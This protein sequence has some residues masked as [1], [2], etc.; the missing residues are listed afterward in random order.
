MNRFL[1]N[2]GR[3]VKSHKNIV[4]IILAALFLELISAAQYYYAHNLLEKEM[5]SRAESELSIKA[6]LIKGILNMAEKT[7]KEHV[8]DFKRN[9]SHPD[10]MFAATERTIENSPDVKGF[11]LAFVP[12]YYQE[13]GRLFEPYVYKEND[14][15]I[16]KQ[17]GDENEHDY[18][19][20]PAFQRMVNEKMPLWSDPYEYKTTN[21]V[22][23]LI[24]Y[25]YPLLDKK[26]NLV[27]VCG[28][29][30]SLEQIGD[31][32]NYRHIYPSSFNLLLTQSG[33]II[34]RP[35]GNHVNYDDVE[36][37]VR[38]INDSTVKRT[39]SRSGR[40]K[41]IV[42]KSEKD[43][44]RGVI[45]YANM[46]GN[47]KWQV[48]VVSYEDEIYGNLYWMRFNLLL[49]LLLAFG[50][51]GYIV[52][53]Y[54]RNEKDLHRANLKQERIDS[55]LR[56]AQNIQMDMLPKVFPP[57]PE[58]NDIQ[59]FGFLEPAKEVGGDI[60]DFFI[61]DEKLLFCIGDVSGKGVPSAIVMAE[62][63]SQFR[64]V[65][66]H[67]KNPARMMQTLNVTLCEGN[68]TNIF[69]TF[70]IGV[71]D[72][73]SGRLRYC[74]A[75][76]DIPF[77]ISDSE[78]QM[79]SALPMKANIPIGLFD[80]FQY[81]GQ[82]CYIKPETTL[83]LY[84]DGLTEA[85]NKTH[86]LFDIKRVEESLS[87]CVNLSPEE[88]IQIMKKKVRLFVEDAEQSDDLTMLCIKYTPKF[89]EF[90]AKEE[91][92]LKNDVKDVKDLNAFVKS[93]TDK[94]EIDK[95]QA[96][97]IKLAVEEAVVNVMSYA[98][99]VGTEG[100]IIVRAIYNNHKLMFVIIDEGIAFDPTEK[101]KADTTLSVEDRPVGGLGLLLVR[102]MMDSIN[103]ERIDNKNK[104]TLITSYKKKTIQ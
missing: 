102:E 72:L 88:I 14:K 29:D 31:T 87:D 74:N 52:Q 15:N 44:D 62:I 48:V 8:W 80:D 28:L 65:S 33:E 32:L 1:V 41:Y 42:F 38:L 4:V 27:A 51:L 75:G 101:A 50:I 92:M 60:F 22:Q 54:A 20:H 78:K 69:V 85:K 63:H 83:F 104:L 9:I 23:S 21:T 10:S 55:E 43:N 66:V 53:K 13:K 26:D 12:Y 11:C 98:Y 68:E 67:E 19:Q 96:R 46:K 25:S 99:P 45:Y 3:Y 40:T 37:V 76:H 79:V 61:R 30:L 35:S 89:D 73:P 6:V 82:E 71:L 56:I 57:Y 94:L 2:I 47:P 17:L 18:T 24:T 91:I 58:R 86:N 90:E 95:S 36:Q 103:Y 64:M 81:E 100:D 97:N 70:F 16:V 59:I 39:T 34:S 7:M 93:I 5:D 84:T 49:L 77:V